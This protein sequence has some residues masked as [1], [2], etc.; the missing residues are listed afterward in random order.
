M[1]NTSSSLKSIVRKDFRLQKSRRAIN[2]SLALLLFVG[3]AFALSVL[4]FVLTLI[5]GAGN[6]LFP[7][8]FLI[9]VRI[10]QFATFIWSIFY[11]VNTSISHF[12]LLAEPNDSPE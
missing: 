11:F 4:A 7:A 5:N 9:V 6:S 8:P 12:E 2:V 1:E 3:F 10:V